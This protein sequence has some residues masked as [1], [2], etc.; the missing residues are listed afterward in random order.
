[1]IEERKY[2]IKSKPN[3]LNWTELN[4]VVLKVQHIRVITSKYA[5]NWTAVLLWESESKKVDDIQWSP[6][7]Y[8]LDFVVI[9]F[10]SE[11]EAELCIYRSKKE[12]NTQQSPTQIH[13]SNK[14]NFELNFELNWTELLNCFKSRCHFK[15]DRRD[16]DVWKR[17]VGL[18]C[19]LVRG[20]WQRLRETRETQ[21]A[22]LRAL[23]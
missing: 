15:Y 4:E 6:N 7:H 12:D 3:K 10:C 19:T 1:M 22:G 17:L 5:R 23:K 18:R 8:R 13:K 11:T 9:F 2:P 20:T 21:A 14:L 16:H